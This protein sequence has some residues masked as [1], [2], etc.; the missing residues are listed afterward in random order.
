MSHS[1]Y[2]LEWPLGKRRSIRRKQSDFKA[3][4]FG[5]AR[6]DVFAELRR[7]NASDVVMSTNIPLRGDGIPY[8]NW[9][10]PEDPGVAVYF[11]L[12]AVGE[13]LGT[14][15]RYYAIACDSY[16]KVEENMRALANTL[17]AMRTIERHGSSQMLEQAMSGFAAI[18]PPVDP[19]SWWARLG[20]GSRPT[21]DQAESRW[22]D[23][24]KQHHPDRGGSPERMAE[25]NAAIEQA[26]RC[27]SKDGRQP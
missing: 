16:R 19:Q 7:F 23:L 22:R 10:Q 17:A 1:P 14:P 9:R 21:L 26:R 13:P 5:R 24:V 4:A 2:P 12:R 6:D 15:R 3:L 20:F 11:S 8:A 25:I 27:Y 18:P